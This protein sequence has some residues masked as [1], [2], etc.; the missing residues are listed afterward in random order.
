MDNLTELRIEYKY[1]DKVRTTPIFIA[2]DE[3]LSF[4]FDEFYG[5]L[6][7]EVPYLPKITLE[8]MAL[9]FAILDE[10]NSEVDNSNKYFSSQMFSFDNKG[11]KVISI[12]I[13][14]ESPIAAESSSMS[15]ASKVR[16]SNEVPQSKRCLNLQNTVSQST[17]VSTNI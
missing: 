2:D 8:S 9:R 13:V 7:K 4:T 16:G 17:A 11:M 14:S 5:L 10:N 15:A 6:L 3:L 1:Y 12:R